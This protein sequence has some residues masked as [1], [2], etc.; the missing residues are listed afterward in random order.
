MGKYFYIIGKNET[1]DTEKTI[2]YLN[3]KKT[4]TKLPVQVEH[5]DN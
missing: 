4:V 1:I 3:W 5:K 2:F